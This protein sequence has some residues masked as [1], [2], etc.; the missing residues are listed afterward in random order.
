MISFYLHIKC[1]PFVSD[2][3]NICTH[4]LCMIVLSGSPLCRGVR[5]CS[6]PLVWESD[7]KH[8]QGHLHVYYLNIMKLFKMENINLRHL[9][10]FS[11]GL[12]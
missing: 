2:Y 12:C 1:S 3:V 6:D 9:L 7:L 8:L 11:R 4:L 10:D 5:D